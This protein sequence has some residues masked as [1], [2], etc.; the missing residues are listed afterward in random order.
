MSIFCGLVHS[1]RSVFVSYEYPAN[2]GGIFIRPAYFFFPVP[3]YSFI[4]AT[5]S[6]KDCFAPMGA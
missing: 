4:H 3:S 1:H 6:V 5:M 2:V